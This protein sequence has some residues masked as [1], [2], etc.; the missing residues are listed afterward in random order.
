MKLAVSEVFYSIQGEG[1]TAG[2][3]S[4]FIRLTGCN[5]LCGG[6]GTDKDNELHNG[7]TWRCDTIE[8]WQTGTKKDISQV[9]GQN[10][11]VALKNG[12]S[13]IFTGGEPLIQQKGII[14]FIDYWRSRL[15]INF[16]VEIETNGTLSVSMDLAKFGPQINCSPKLSNSGNERQDRLKPNVIANL[17]ELKTQYKFVISGWDDWEEIRNEWSHLVPKHK[18]V[19]MPAGESQ[20]ELAKVREVVANIAIANGVKYCDRLHIVLW[21]QKT[22][23]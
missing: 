2:N 6:P 10:E 17:N 22:G 16:P 14:E 15:G 5:L 23:V 13:V 9:L 4:V 12:A 3:P 11:I 19:L 20:D 7:A 1:V 8:V 18:I 21:N